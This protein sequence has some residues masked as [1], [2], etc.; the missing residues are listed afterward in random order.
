MNKIKKWII[1]FISV[2]VIFILSI[3]IYIYKTHKS[4]TSA[5]DQL[6]EIKT[7]IVSLDTL[8]SNIINLQNSQKMFLFS[9]EESYKTNY[10][11]YLSTV[12]EN[13]N[14]LAKDNVITTDSQNNI[15]NLIKD[16]DSIYQ[17]LSSSQIT[18]P[19]T[20]DKQSLL[21][22]S[23]EIE[24]Q[25]LDSISSSISSNT[26]STTASH[27]ALTS[28]MSS[29]KKVVQAISSI[30]T[31]II[32]GPVCFLLN[33]FKNGD[34]K[35]DDIK[36]TL[37]KEKQKLFNYVDM[38]KYNTMINTHNKQMEK[39]WQDVQTL[40]ED[41]IGKFD[42]LSKQLEAIKD[43]SSN[44]ADKSLSSIK[45]NLIELKISVK[46]LPNYHEFIIGLTDSYLNNNK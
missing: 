20:S 3:N 43:V 35:L 36:N 5:V 16:Y 44:E 38:I 26:D 34:I 11:K 14:D 15:L 24:T 30:F 17:Q 28:S 9:Q 39:E 33:K 1:F 23:N 27:T 19:L 32:G 41:L 29:Q 37:D 10:S 6:D 40:V 46:Q 2:L 31:L 22:K 4:L 7:D 18:L 25:L 8:K 12:T 42:D 45:L 21:E 13:V